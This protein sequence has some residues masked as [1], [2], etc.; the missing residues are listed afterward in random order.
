[1]TGTRE[2]LYEE[3][4]AALGKATR[5]VHEP[6]AFEALREGNRIAF[7]RAEIP[8]YEFAAAKTVFT[9][10]ADFVDTWVSPVQHARGFADSHGRGALAGGRCVTFE[11]RL[12]L[13][14]SNADEW[15]AIRPGTEALVALALAQSIL[16]QGLAKG[17]P[18]AF[19]GLLAGYAPEK[20]ADRVGV[21]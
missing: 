20:V 7:G 21:P 15:V 12:S 6:F 1:E 16:S 3:W 5:V 10:G 19:G 18:G 17:S 9:L 13:T 11:P 2:R 14:G 8:T 4:V